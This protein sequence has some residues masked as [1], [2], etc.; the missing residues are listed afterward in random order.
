MA[1]LE[2]IRSKSV[3]LLVIIGLAL[4]AFIVGDFF[5]SGRT[6]FGTGSTVAEIAGQKID[7]Q[8][9]QRR[10]SEASQ[11]AQQSGRKVDPA[12]LQQQVLN[13]MIA[14]A[15]FDKEA[16]ELG[17]KVT[18][19]ELSQA[20]LGAGAPYLDRMVQQ[21]TGIES[22]SVLHDM[23]FN[24][25]KYSLD[26]SQAVQLQNYWISLEKQMEESLLQQKFQNLF[27][28]TLVAN[29]LDAR[30]L[31]DENATT[32]QIVFAKAD[33]STEDDDKYPVSDEEIEAQWKKERKR[34]AINEPMR[35]IGYINVPIEPSQADRQAAQAKVEKAVAALNEKPGTEGIEGMTEFI[36]NRTK[37]TLGK[38]AD[39]SVKN[40]LS[41]DSAGRAAVITFTN[42]IYTIGKVLGR[43]VA[44]D[45]VNI[46]MLA[47]QGAKTQID[48]LINGLNG[49]SIK[50][51]DL[52]KAENVQGSQ[53]S[54]W[55]SLID[56]QVAQVRSILLD[57]ATGVYFTPDTAANLQGA[58]IF[59]VNSRKA[60]VTVYDVALV[61][62]TVEPGAAT[63]NGLLTSLQKFLNENKTAAD[64]AANAEK[65]GYM[66]SKANITP[67]TPLVSNI[68]GSRQALAW[69]L[70]AKKGAVSPV[71]GD[72]STGSFM[73]VAVNDIYEG[74]YAPATDPS[75]R[76][77]LTTQVR[78]DKKAKA[79]IERYNGKA[80][81]ING[82]AKLMG[83][84]AD[85]TNVAFGQYMI[86]KLG[87]GESA[88]AARA[89]VAK[90]G[91]IV[92][93]MQGNSG[94]VVFQVVKNDSEGRPYSFDESA[95]MYLRSRGAQA[96]GNQLNAILQ[97]NE[98]IE[99]NLIKFY[100]N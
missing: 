68:E 22:A 31:Y 18:D 36:S 59:R 30:A 75:I 56:P 94:V 48:S 34:F 10:V 92:G 12:V 5:T 67:S 70:D 66:A 65:A 26:E 74:D 3:L 62:Y 46:D 39:K 45:S 20:M 58:R 8:E 78:N 79:I 84:Q 11:Q 83:T 29:E 43:E 28:G 27:M 96:L 54:L 17:L 57:A 86:P 88:I 42:D 6:L 73:A 25:A 2:K 44:V 16:E 89:S 100:P 63:V 47:V 98:K 71:F 41:S 60:P 52:A 23:A 61:N 9:F 7:I 49:G 69:A 97:G 1:T 55:V 76:E 15:L 38:V 33:F 81:D 50:F 53:D 19:E 21:Q 87:I 24:A 72:E 64:F 51:D 77:I 85:T 37:T 13:G 91:Q 99:N 35:H 80:K 40:F 90:P 95:M 14:E 82:Y 93:P 32:S 4:L